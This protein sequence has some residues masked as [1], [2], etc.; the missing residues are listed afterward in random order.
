[1]AGAYAERGFFGVVKVQAQ[2]G[3]QL[4]VHGT[5]LHGAQ[6]IGEDA[7]LPATYYAASTPIGQVFSAHTDE[8]RVA[9]VGLG[10]GSVACYA[11]PGQ[12]YIYFE[13]DPIVA[14]FASDPARFTYLSTCT[15][16][17][18]IVLGDGR[19]TLANE[20]EAAFELLLI[21][22]FS[23]DSVPAHL[24][25]R[26]AVSLYLSR[27][28]QDDGI[29]LLHVSNQHMA[30]ATVVS[31]IAADLGVP[32][33]MQYYTPPTGPDTKP[34]HSQASIVVALAHNEA[35]LASLAAADGWEPVKSDGGRAWSD[36]F[37][38]IP[39]AIWDRLVHERL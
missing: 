5:T 13:I 34:F 17:A 39:G 9:V 18:E 19:L 32:G 16:D 25:T 33:R 22:A 27:V 28:S 4:M 24:L 38:N 2:D 20:P 36:D 10:V 23:S 14:R 8:G 11:K 6:A 37:S 35:A 31:R 21:D 30:L 1:M 3:Y 29:V 15:P 12:D 26:E 7:L